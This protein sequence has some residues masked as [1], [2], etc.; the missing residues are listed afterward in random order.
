MAI[1]IGSSK[2]RKVKFNFRGNPVY[3][4]K[5]PLMLGLKMQSVAEGEVMPPEII[6]EIIA[7]CVVDEDGNCLWS[8]EDVLN[9]DLDPMLKLFGEVSGTSLKVGDAEKN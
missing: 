2:P 1:E 8:M 5:M 6:G 9:F 3:V 4:R 7:A